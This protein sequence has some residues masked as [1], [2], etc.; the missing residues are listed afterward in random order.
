MVLYTRM[1]S[2]PPS[3][4]NRRVPVERAK[5]G[6][7]K[8]A[9]HEVGYVGALLLLA[10]VPFE[11]VQRTGVSTWVVASEVKA[12]FGIALVRFGCPS[13]KSAGAVLAVGIEFQT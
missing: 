10:S 2:L 8:V 5:R 12:L 7:F 9:L 1:R 4:T 13:A 11:T 6:K 3:A